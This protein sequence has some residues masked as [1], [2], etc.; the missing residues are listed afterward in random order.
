MSEM[1]TKRGNMI[2]IETGDVE[3]YCK[4]L[5]IR[6]GIRLTE[7]TY[8]EQVRYSY[9]GEY[10]V[11]NNELYKLRYIEDLEYGFAEAIQKE[12]GSIDFML[13][14]YNGGAIMEEVLED[15]IKR[16]DK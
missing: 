12:D 5:C 10:L 2:K 8:S 11:V 13:R 4:E 7:E 6:D 1:E 9:N 15:A 14:W 3:Q 16:M